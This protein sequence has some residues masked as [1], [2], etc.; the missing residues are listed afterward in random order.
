MT[1]STNVCAERCDSAP[2]TMQTQ[3]NLLCSRSFIQAETAVPMLIRALGHQEYRAAMAAL[4]T[5]CNLSAQ[6]ACLQQHT[7]DPA[8][9]AALERVLL[10]KRLDPDP[11]V[12]YQT[13]LC[14]HAAPSVSTS[15]IVANAR[16]CALAQFAAARITCWHSVAQFSTFM[17]CRTLVAA[18]GTI[19][20]GYQEHTRLAGA[21]LAA[22]AQPVRGL[23]CR[24]PRPKHPSWPH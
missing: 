8:M 16:G 4:A 12:F 19:T 24:T 20:C 17:A 2:D 9:L 5:L 18:A 22:I 23:L 1:C 15:N 6:P 21:R 11:Q 10:Q 7:N 3:Q 13:L 14:C